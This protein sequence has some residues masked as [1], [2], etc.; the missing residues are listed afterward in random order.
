MKNK[1]YNTERH[2]GCD[3]YAGNDVPHGPSNAVSMEEA[4]D[5]CFRIP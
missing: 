2:C 5:P 3:C 4:P 1:G